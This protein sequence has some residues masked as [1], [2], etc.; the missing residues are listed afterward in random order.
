VAISDAAT[1]L[2]PSRARVL[3]T[4]AIGV[5]AVSAAAIFIRYA[6]LAGAPSLTIAAGRLVMASLVM[7]PIALISSRAT[8]ATL[9]RTDWARAALVGAL[10]AAHFWAWI[11]SLSYVSVAISTVLVTTTPVWVAL[12]AWLFRGERLGPRQVLG[13]VLA[14][15]GSVALA[16]LGGNMGKVESLW[17]GALLALG[18]AWAIAGNMLIGQSLRG[19]LPVRVYAALAYGWAALWLV[20]ALVVTGTSILGLAPAAYG[21]M[22]ALALVPQVIGHTALNWALPYLGA[23]TVAV[24]ILGEPIGAALIAT[25]LL[26][27]PVS[28]WMVL[29][30][31]LTLV[32]IVL[33]ALKK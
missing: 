5:L 3:A 17:T 8:F 18:G 11:A 24:S 31:G 25:W 4:L 9:T 22:L 15:A 26:N 30:F 13:L 29:C 20:L 12:G 27:E 10:L 16:V 2:L 23:T 21:Y 32:G 28:V 33:V 6:Q 14:V 19:K 7:V 1:V